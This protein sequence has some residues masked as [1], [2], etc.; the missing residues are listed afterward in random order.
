MDSIP[1]VPTD[2]DEA[3]PF[4]M[5][6]EEC[7]RRA[8]MVELEVA[9]EVER[10]PSLAACLAGDV[11]SFDRGEYADEASESEPQVEDRSPLEVL[12]PGRKNNSTDA[13]FCDFAFK[14]EVNCLKNSF[15]EASAAVEFWK[16]KAVACQVGSEELNKKLADSYKEKL[17]LQSELREERQKKKELEARLGQLSIDR[18]FLLVEGIPMELDWGSCR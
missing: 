5:E 6:D 11:L 10:V 4:D 18:N 3:V 8:V 9:T 13:A 16:N 15:E 17:E 1:T 2:N 7:Y 12:V 14:I